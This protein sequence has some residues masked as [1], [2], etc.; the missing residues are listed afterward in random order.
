MTVRWRRAA[1]AVVGTAMLVVLLCVASLL[2]VPLLVTVVMSFDARPYLGPMPPPEYSLRWYR[3]LFSR[4]DLM[5]GLATSIVLAT[6]TTAVSGALG[7]T[8]ALFFHDRQFPGREVLL[9]LSLSPLIVP[10][11]VIGFALLLFLS[12]FGFLNGMA[13]LLCGHVVITFPFAFR[14][15]LAALA[16]RDRFLGEAAMSLGA[17][18]WS[19]FWEI[20]FPLIRTGIVAGG[21]M[22][23]AVSMDDVAVASFL[24]GIDTL[25]LP[26][27]LVSTARASF[28]MT[29]A[30]A[31]ISLL[32]ATAIVMLVLSRFIRIGSIVGGSQHDR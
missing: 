10:P 28:D 15:T 12:Q 5:S 31:A 2:L 23:F 26:V 29:V 11:V 1:D 14:A 8:T 7:V 13:R 6:A 21:V 24:S 25:T 20:T 16:G 4:A 30:A 9:A 18:P 27:T 22:V 32:V 19:T 17:T 3:Q